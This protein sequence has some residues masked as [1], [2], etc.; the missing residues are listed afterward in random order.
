MAIIA[1]YPVRQAGHQFEKNR[2]AC[3]ALIAAAILMV[4]SARYQVL[5]GDTEGSNP[6]P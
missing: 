3:H 1:T 4:M 6:A 2:W 5:P